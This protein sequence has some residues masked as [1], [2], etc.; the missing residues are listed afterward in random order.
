M[1]SWI[2]VGPPTFGVGVRD[3][4]HGARAAAATVSTAASESGGS[5]ERR[6]DLHQAVGH[7][8]LAV[9]ADGACDVGDAVDLRG[10]ARRRRACAALGDDHRGL[11]VPAGEVAGQ[12]LL[13]GR[14][15]RPR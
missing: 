15:S 5:V 14:P 1:S 9:R 7:A 11:P 12:H 10:V 8:G 2:A 4:V 3:R 13:A 6:V